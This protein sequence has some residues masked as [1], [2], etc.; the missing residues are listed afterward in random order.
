MAMGTKNYALL[1]LR[2]TRSRVGHRHHDLVE[3]D[4]RKDFLL[5]PGRECDQSAGDEDEHEDVRG[6]ILA[7]G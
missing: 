7:R 6:R 5:D 2:R 3:V 4:F 1:D